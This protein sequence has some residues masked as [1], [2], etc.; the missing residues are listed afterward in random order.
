MVSFTYSIVSLQFICVVDCVIYLF[1]AA[2]GL[3]LL[4]GLC[5]VVA[6]GATLELQCVGFSL[7]WRLLF[8]STGSRMYQF[9]GCGACAWLPQGS[10]WT[11]DRTCVPWF[12]K[13]ILNQWTT[14][15]THV[16]LFLR[17]DN[18]GIGG[19]RRRGQQRMRWLDAVTDSMDMSLSELQEL[20][21]DKEAWHAAIHGVTKSQTWLSNW[22]ELNNPLGLSRWRSGKE[23]TRQ[24]TR[25]WSLGQACLQWQSTPVFLPEK[26]HGQRS[27][28][29][30]SP[31]GLIRVRHDWATKHSNP[32][33]AC[34][35]FVY[36][37]IHP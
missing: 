19:R 17:L 2:L 10:S 6:S 35:T 9:R 23:S 26:S 16:I 18:G 25:V 7:W 21:M 31:Q 15:E 5:L 13:P 37:L 33:C 12:G 22:T 4:C 36:S 34:A 1:M 27:L 11:R 24:E 20:V 14:T 29:G 30:S 28:V 32:L 3:P 8:R